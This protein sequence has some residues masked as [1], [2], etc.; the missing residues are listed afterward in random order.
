MTYRQLTVSVPRRRYCRDIA[1]VINIGWT[2]FTTADGSSVYCND[3]M[4][5]ISLPPWGDL[6]YSELDF[7]HGGETTRRS[8]R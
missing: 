6:T 3:S 2:A 8:L 1:G 4:R 5:C 7:G